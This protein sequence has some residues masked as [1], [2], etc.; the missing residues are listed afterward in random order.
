MSR[1]QWSIMVQSLF[2]LNSRSSM[3][4]YEKIVRCITDA[5]AAKACHERIK[6]CRQ[7]GLAVSSDVGIISCYDAPLEEILEGAITMISKDFRQ[8]GINTA[9]RILAGRKE[10]SLIRPDR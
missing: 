2:R 1:W 5:A 3:T 10:K 6:L 7:K 4:R 8:M 9:K